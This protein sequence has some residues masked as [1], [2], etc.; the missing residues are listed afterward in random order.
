M[1]KFFIE[2]QSEEKYH[3]DLELN[4]ISEIKNTWNSI[5]DLDPH[6][7]CI[8]FIDA[9]MNQANNVFSEPTLSLL[10]E[11]IKVN[12]NNNAD[13]MSL[14]KHIVTSHGGTFAINKVENPL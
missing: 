5:K 14:L 1:T 6:A 10:N 8:Q 11:K 13:G 12:K 4:T 3:P 9:I 2:D 7:R